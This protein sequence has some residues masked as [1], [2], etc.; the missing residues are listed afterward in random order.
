M[1]QLDKVQREL[2][3]EIGYND[4]HRK[5]IKQRE[6]EIA[7][8]QKNE[9]K[10]TKELKKIQSAQK[11]LDKRNQDYKQYNKELE[12]KI[13]MKEDKIKTMQLEKRNQEI[14]S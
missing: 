6:D 8:H 3:K 11:K 12:A 4:E 14:T 9:H 7:V 13:L 5:R 2:E 10:L 1:A